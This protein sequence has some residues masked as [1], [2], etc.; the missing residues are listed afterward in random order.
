[1]RSTVAA[2]MFEPSAGIGERI[3]GNSY[4]FNGK[5]YDEDGAL[6]GV[7]LRDGVYFFSAAF[8]ARHGHGADAG[9]RCDGFRAAAEADVHR[10]LHLCPA[11]LHRPAGLCRRHGRL[12]QALRADGRL[13]HCLARRL[14]DHQC[15]EGRYAELQAL[16]AHRH[17]RR[18][19]ADVCRWPDLH[20]ARHG[21]QLGRGACH[22]SAAVH[23]RRHH[24]MS[25]GGVPRRQGQ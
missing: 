5:R 1:M 14:S 9:A 24:Q 2:L 13:H 12:R 8:Y 16:C 15:I 19:P 11:R 7:L 18:H 22:G 10:A 4:G 23:S 17:R 3:R 21:C 6:R 25:H 20:D